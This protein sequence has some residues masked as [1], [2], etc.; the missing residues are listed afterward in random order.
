MLV[1][2]CDLYHRLRHCRL[3]YILYGIND[4][5]VNKPGWRVAFEHWHN[6]YPLYI[7][8]QTYIY[9]AHGQ[10]KMT[11]Y[12]PLNLLTLPPQSLDAKPTPTALAVDPYADILWVGTSSGIVSAYCSPLSLASNIRFPA[13]GARP[14]GGSGYIAPGQGPNVKEIRV[15]DREI[16]TL[17]EGGVG[18]RRRGGAVKWN[19]SDPTRSLRS[20]AG[21]PTNSHEVLAGGTGQMILANTS[22][23][24]VVRRVRSL[25]LD[26]L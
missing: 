20:M 13:H 18:G 9:V 21:N 2:F 7:L 6:V 17:A 23:G 5:V 3:A 1:I 12:N 16:W 25:R 14:L 26:T 22:R 8:E 24:E 4:N 11:T 10:G 15:S 19:V